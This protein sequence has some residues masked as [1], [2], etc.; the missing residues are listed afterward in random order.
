MGNPKGGDKMK[1]DSRAWI[2]FTSL[3]I[4]LI[5][6]TVI[7]PLMPK[8]LDHYGLKGG[9]SLGSLQ[10]FIQYLQEK[11]NIPDNFNTV[12]IGGA[13]GSLFSFLQFIASPLAGCLSDR[14]G[15]KPALIVSMIGIACSYLIWAVADSFP[16]FVLARATGGISKANVSL[17]TAVMADITDAA[18]RA[19]SMAL[20]GIAFAAG[21]IIGP[22][23]G[24]AFS[25]WGVDSQ[26]ETN[27]WLWP[28]V[29][30]LT[31]ATANIAFVIVF[32]KESLPEGKRAKSLHLSQAWNLVNPFSL[33]NFKLAE[34]LAKKADLKKM[35]IPST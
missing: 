25:L 27:W 12:L 17:A 11:L 23:T 5:G 35:I 7:L 32:F 18:T 15:R 9:T 26:Q 33:F 2:I 13:L 16:I 31:L 10:N 34:G 19:K 14:Y 8:L 24:A 22:M 30:A 4:D 29:F 3:V 28:A 6:F 1:L 20:I 21:F